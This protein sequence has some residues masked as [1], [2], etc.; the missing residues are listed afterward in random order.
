[1]KNAI[2][3][4]P[5]VVIGAGSGGLVIAVGA[6]KAGKDVLLV[7]TGS[8]GGDCTNFGCI[9]SK[10]LLASSK[11][12]PETALEDVR[13]IV[14]E[15]RA[16]E[17][18]Q[19]LKELGIDTKEGTASFIDPHHIDID[20]T[21]IHA[22]KIVIATGSRP[23]IPN[24]DGLASTPYLTNE[25]IFSLP[26]PPSSLAILGG[27]PIGCELGQAFARMG[28]KVTM[29]LRNDTVLS[30]EDPE[31]QSVLK[32]QLQT[33]GITFAAAPSKITHDGT[34]FSTGT[35]HLLVATGRSPNL[36]TLSLDNA[37]IKYTEEGI[38]TTKY[39][40]TSQSHIYAIG[41]VIGKGAYT[42][43]AEHHARSV[44]L[45]LITP[46][47]RKITPTVLP[48]VTYTTPEVA[49]FGLTEQNANE[50]YG[51]R[52][53]AIYTSPLSEN[54]RAL[55]D[56]TQVGFVKI[57]TKKLS[58]K[59]IGATIVAPH[60]GEMLQE[61]TLASQEHIPLRKLATLVHPYPT[62]A[63]AIRKAADQYL[64]N[65]L[66][67]S[68]KHPWSLLNWKRILPITGILILMFLAY[69]FD[70]HSYFSLDTLREHHQ[71]L[72]SWVTAHPLLAALLYFS[73]YIAATALSFPGAA[74]LSIIGGF[75]FPFPISTLLVVTGATIGASLI[76]LTAKTALG[77][78]L[79]KK[80][81]PFLAKLQKGFQESAWS[82]LLFLRLVP[83]FPFW[84]V[85]IAP[86]LFSI[87]LR[88]FVWTT[89]VGI[90]PG[91]IAYTLA[92]S[93]LGTILASD[94]T[95]SLST[96]L[97][98]K[99]KIALALIGIMALLPILIKKLRKRP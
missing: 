47:K 81:G 27:G 52:H 9:P 51:K 91:A 64:L 73:I 31:A 21:T 1:M 92:G 49:S 4:Y 22:R 2:H 19:A 5:L 77:E 97:N 14:A 41:D 82:Y 43:L 86:A 95:F 50:T 16:K 13:R 3:S 59:I 93:G 87:P 85:N 33:E 72:A 66:L 71:A 6:A 37:H 38:T 60:A 53:I 18:P 48:H 8:W 68:L 28:T 76:F 46:F 74:I 61:L 10:T 75:L 56:Q 80:A 96:I 63:L 94:G 35:E 17:S 69:I 40:K 36:E 89:F 88:T 26:K 7:D 54:D 78:T 23:H 58:S 55:T 65:T 67:P 98:T 20:G 57:I 34:T 44:L 30:K 11:T 15:I 12:N 45:S 32:K 70:L 83:L 24:I 62:Y 39:G 29:L 25:T 79:Q 42:H 90:I 84:L 99:L